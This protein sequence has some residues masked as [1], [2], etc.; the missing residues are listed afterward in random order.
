[1][2]NHVFIKRGLV[3]AFIALILQACSSAPPDAHLVPDDP[4]LYVVRADEPVRLDGDAAWENQTWGWRSTLPEQVEFIVFAPG[5]NLAAKSS[6][7][8]FLRNVAWVRSEVSPHGEIMPTSGSQ[9]DV[10]AL[11]SY[12]VPATYSIVAGRADTIRVTPQAPLQPGLYAFQLRGEEV[13]DAR[14]GVNW[15]NLDQ[16]AYAAAHCVDLYQNGEG[17]YRLEPCADQQQLAAANGAGLGA[18]DELDIQ[19]GTPATEVVNGVATLVIQGVVTSRSDRVQAIPLLD[20]QL[21]DGSGQLL[22]TW[23][24]A[25][26]AQEIAPGQSISFETQAPTLPEGTET[27]NVTFSNAPAG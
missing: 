25:P 9:W 26:P 19:L 10:P 24:I 18:V 20:A 2:R 4:G 16:D 3:A 5:E 1:M 7:K 22:T 27:V 15:P 8:I 14:F 11:E 13:R 21:L 17:S 12:L 6:Q 23:K